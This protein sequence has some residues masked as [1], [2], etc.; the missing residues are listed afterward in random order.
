VL[1]G[2]ALGGLGCPWLVVWC[3]GSVQWGRGLSAVGGWVPTT[4]RADTDGPPGTEMNFLFTLIPVRAAART[5]RLRYA[6]TAVMFGLV[7]GCAVGTAAARA[8][9]AAWQWQPAPSDV[10]RTA[11]PCPGGAGGAVCWSVTEDRS[12]WMAVPAGSSY[13]WGQCTYYVGLMR[14]DIWNDRAPA[15]VDQGGDWDAWT[16]AEHAAAEGLVVDGTPAAGDVMVYSRRAVGNDTGHVA[17]VDAV[18]GT[19]RRTGEVRLTVSEMNAEGLDDARRGQGDT[20][21]VELPRSELVAG[22]IQFIH[23]PPAGYVAPVW[24]DGTGD[25][26]PAATATAAAVVVS[27]PSLAVG[28]SAGQLATVSRSSAPERAVV[29]SLVTGRVVSTRRVAANRV[30][31][32]RLPG[33]RYRV[34]V[35]QAATGRWAPANACATGSWRSPP[36]H[37]RPAGLRGDRASRGSPR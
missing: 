17:I 12:A 7:F 16:W 19:D 35:A 18:A 10:V 15:S 23:Q 5:L 25:P 13:G 27:D 3:P 14:P 9:V 4:V 33:G 37:P 32:L 6:V 36:S 31:T 34:C 11:R 21:R 24:P 20:V 29:T 8:D 22:M 26:G 30:V 2:A 1:C 28:V